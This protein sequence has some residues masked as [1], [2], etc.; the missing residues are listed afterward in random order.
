MDSKFQNETFD[1]ICHRLKPALEKLD[2][3]YRVSVPLQKR[4]AIA[5]WKL[6]TNSEYR[7]VSHL[8][9]VGNSTA[10]DCVKDFCSSVEYILLPEVITIPQTEKLKE[11]SLNF[12]QRWGLPQCVGAIDGSYSGS[13]GIPH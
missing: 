12:E 6:A 11:L 10:C 13:P 4:V 5:L 7:S 3:N 9:G 2:T 8:F 1:Y